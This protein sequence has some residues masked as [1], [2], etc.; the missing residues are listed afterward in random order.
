LSFSFLLFDLAD[1]LDL[2]QEQ[3]DE[4]KLKLDCTGGGRIRVNPLTLTI[5]VYGYSMV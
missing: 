3:I 2:L 5:S 1:V 4:T